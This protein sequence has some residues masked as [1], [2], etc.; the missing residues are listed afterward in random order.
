MRVAQALGIRNHDALVDEDSHLRTKTPDSIDDLRLGSG[1]RGPP[2]G[3]DESTPDIAVVVAS[4]SSPTPKLA[5]QGLVH[6]CLVC[7]E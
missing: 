7:D 6:M 5:K 3:G 1:S 4:D 2:S